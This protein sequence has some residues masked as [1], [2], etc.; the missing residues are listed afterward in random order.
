MSTGDEVYEA[1]SAAGDYYCLPPP[2]AES[3]ARIIGIKDH[4]NFPRALNPADTLHHFVEH[5]QGLYNLRWLEKLGPN[6]EVLEWM[7]IWGQP[8]HSMRMFYDSAKQRWPELPG[9]EF[10]RQAIAE[11]SKKNMKAFRA[12][13][14]LPEQSRRRLQK[15]ELPAEL[16][17]KVRPLL[18]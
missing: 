16:K 18:V 15:K 4:H 10:F 5:W 13:R 7:L 12:T 14:L 2:V 8:K 11:N 3:F 1:V 17:S 6:G 9:W